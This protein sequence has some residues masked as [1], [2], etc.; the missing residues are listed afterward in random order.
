MGSCRFSISGGVIVPRRFAPHDM[1][2]LARRTDVIAANIEGL[3]MHCATSGQRL[4][5][6][7]FDM[8]I[9]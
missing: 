8:T 3:S 4:P 1:K 7:M 6:L 2:L 9:T 5:L